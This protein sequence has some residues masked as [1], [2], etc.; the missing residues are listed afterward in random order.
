MSELFKKIDNF[1]KVFEYENYCNFEECI[2]NKKN[3]DIHYPQLVSLSA[4]KDW[5]VKNTYY[6]EDKYV[7]HY[8]NVLCGV[9]H[10]RNTIV[11][12]KSEEKLSIKFFIYN[13]RRNVG[14]RFFRNKC[15]FYY[16]TFNYKTQSTFIGSIQNYNKK[17]KTVKK[18]IKNRFNELP[19]NIIKTTIRNCMNN[20][21]F[22]SNFSKTED[23]LNT[24]EEIFISNII[25]YDSYMTP[26]EILYTQYS[27]KFGIKH[28]DN[29]KYFYTTYPQPTIKML[30]KYD[31]RYIDSYMSNHNLKGDKIKKVLHI[32]KER[33]N[34]VNF[35][36]VSNFFG[37]DYVLGKSDDFLVKLF[38]YEPIYT[39]ING[40]FSKKE[41]ENIFNILSIVL[42]KEIN[43]RTFFD[44]IYF[45][46]RLK[47][48]ERVKWKSK[49]YE[50][51]MSEHM[52]FSDRI[53]FYTKGIFK[54]KYPDVWVEKIETPIFD[55]H[56][57]LLKNSTDYNNE[58]MIQSNCVKN[59]IS[60]PSSII[61]SLRK[62]GIQSEDR[63]TL[64][65]QIVKI[66]NQIVFSRIQSL[67]RFNESLGNDWNEPLHI[68]DDVLRSLSIDELYET[69]YITNFTKIN[70]GVSFIETPKLIGESNTE[71][72]SWENPVLFE[73]I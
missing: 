53:D 13:R 67:G 71:Y 18:L 56:P 39:E 43:I 57:V 70:S 27:N 19:F 26:D 12:T 47:I 29:W 9:Q 63:A 33:P 31:M 11:I 6:T 36:V 4:K 32:I 28:T 5:S 44:H 41:K 17:R 72:L 64:E 66:N 62:G 55:Y 2:S 51:F 37:K 58:S 10:S 35:H 23:L 40:C 8:S 69:E 59:Y 1:Y 34:P 49:T 54:R 24:I 65:Y 16:L 21:G 60:R 46:N 7:E 22:V 73:L 20:T 42:N 61:I 52:N 38:T 14:S 48:F 15:D 45:I 25:G 3:I 50:E 68:L 30:K